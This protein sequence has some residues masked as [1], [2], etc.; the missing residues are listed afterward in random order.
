[1]SQCSAPGSERN[2]GSAGSL[3]GRSQAKSAARR[4]TCARMPRENSARPTRQTV[5]P[6]TTCRWHDSSRHE[7]GGQGANP[8][9]EP[10]RKA[11]KAMKLETNYQAGNHSNWGKL[12]NK[13]K[14]KHENSRI[15]QPTHTNAHTQQRNSWKANTWTNKPVFYYPHP[16]LRAENNG[17]AAYLVSPFRSFSRCR[18]LLFSSLIVACSWC[19]ILFGW[20]VFSLLLS[21]LIETRV[22]LSDCLLAQCLLSKSE[23]N[24]QS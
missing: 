15:E 14:T 16:S 9:N 18:S 8:S 12:R 13:E 3:V 4:V 19:S 1:M 23:Y 22:F 2:P 7:H 11:K 10:I 20:F 21:V 6:V 17:D 24:N 5:W